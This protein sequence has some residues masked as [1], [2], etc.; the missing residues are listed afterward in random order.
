MIK[1]YSQS[2]TVA[3]FSHNRHEY[4]GGP[5]SVILRDLSH[6]KHEHLTYS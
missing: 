6:V 1:P 4:M 3:D 2:M 5:K